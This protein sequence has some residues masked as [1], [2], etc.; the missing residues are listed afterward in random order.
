MGYEIEFSEEKSL[1][2]K[3][4]RGVSFEDVIVAVEKGRV[5]DDIINKTHPNQRM[6]VVRLKKYVYAVPYVV[7]SKRRKIFLKT[8]YPSRELVKKYGKKG[9][10]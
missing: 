8:I 10:K 5:E 2:L 6:L 1:L 4:T 3:E 7:D 9:K